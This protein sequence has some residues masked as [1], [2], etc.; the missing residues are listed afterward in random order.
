MTEETPTPPED[1][2][3][4]HALLLDG[5]GGATEMDWEQIAGWKPEMG[6][7]WVHLHADNPRTGR[8]L[9]EESRLDPLMAE[10]LWDMDNQPRCLVEESALLA[11]F[12]GMNFNRGAETDDMAILNL[13]S[14]GTRLVTVRSAPLR[15]VRDMARALLV[16]R[17]PRTIGD[18][19]VTL[20]GRLHD[21]MEPVLDGIEEDLDRFENQ[22]LRGDDSGIREP[23][24]EIRSELIGFRKHLTPQRRAL[25]ELTKS[26]PSWLLKR[27]QREF[28]EVENLVGRFLGELD[29]YRDRAMLI[30]EELNNQIAERMNRAMYLLSIVTGVF[31][32]LG[33]LTGLLGINVGGLP[34][35][36]VHWAF[37]AVCGIL[38]IMAGISLFIFR[39]SRLI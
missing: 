15:S 23:L 36:E 20:L 37:W 12:R 25:Q 1:V 3:L 16:G 19:L 22:V 18:L 29:G 26:R 2:S 30:R 38:M 27:H 28:R 5:R 39:R 7:L 8:W 35:T 34:G 33:F 9:N 14:D 6:L 11:T 13:W 21:R 4:I 31:L 10:A 17:G 32:P 24:L